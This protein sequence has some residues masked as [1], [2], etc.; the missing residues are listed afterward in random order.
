MGL[1]GQAEIR[2]EEGRTRE[3]SS[4]LLLCSK[5]PQTKQLKTTKTYHVTQFL[6][7]INPEHLSSL[8][9]AQSLSRLQSSCRPR[10]KP[11]MALMDLLPRRLMHSAVA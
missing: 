11:L 4:Y 2:P 3:C 8:G 10:L 7:I 9:L 1:E 6:K 5:L